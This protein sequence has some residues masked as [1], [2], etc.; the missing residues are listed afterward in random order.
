MGKL[1]NLYHQ[2][3]EEAG[4]KVKEFDLMDP[5]AD[6]DMLTEPDAP[7]PIYS[8]V[9]SEVRLVKPPEFDPIDDEFE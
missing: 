8:P 9:T 2:V 1:Y 3:N 4:L 7:F 6:F 5:G